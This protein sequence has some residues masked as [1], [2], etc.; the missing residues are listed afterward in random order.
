MTGGLSPVLSANCVIYGGVSEIF[1]SPASAQAYYDNLIVQALAQ[2]LA[3][4]LRTAL[5]WASLTPGTASVGVATDF[6]VA[7]TGF[8]TAPVPLVQLDDGAGHVYQPVFSSLTDSAMAW[9]L[10]L[11]TAGTYTLYYSLDA[12]ATWT[13]TLLT[14]TAS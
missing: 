14:V 5:T 8:M 6:V 2:N 4:D 10:S 13:S 3:A 7:G 1:D 12:G 11:L 9:S